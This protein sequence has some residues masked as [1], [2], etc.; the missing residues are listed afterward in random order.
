M[1]D[2]TSLEVVRDPAR[3]SPGRRRQGIAGLASAAALALLGAGGCRIPAARIDEVAADLASL[4]A[5]R[6]AFTL[7]AVRLGRIP[8]RGCAA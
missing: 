8:R 2:L 1:T 6:K 4:A 7:S 3:T 5:K